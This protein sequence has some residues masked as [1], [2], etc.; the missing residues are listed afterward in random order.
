MKRLVTKVVLIVWL[1]LLRVVPSVAVLDLELTKGVDG[2][3]PIAVVPFDWQSKNAKPPE[4]VSS[5]ISQDLSHSGRFTLLESKL[6]TQQPHTA[7][8]VDLSHWRSKNVENVLVGSI[9]PLSDGKY[10]VVYSLLDLYQDKPEVGHDSVNTEK[11]IISQEL[12]VSAA[13]LRRLAHHISDSIYEALTGEKGIFST[14]IAYVLV[15][16]EPGKTTQYLLEVADMDGHNPRPILRSNEPIMSPSWSP[17][18]KKIAYVSFENK[19]PRVY[20]SDLASGKRKMMTSFPGINGAPAWSPDSKQLALA[21]S[22]GLNPNLYLLEVASGVLTQLTNDSA[23]NTE[24][25]WAPDGHSLLFTS[26]RGGTPQIY[27]LA[28]PSKAISRVT[29]DGRYNTTASFSPDGKNL[30]FLHRTDNGFNIATR[31]VDRDALTV[32]THNGFEESPSFAP[33][34]RMIV[35]ATQYGGRGVLGIVS[36]DGRVRLRLPAQKGNVQEPVWSPFAQ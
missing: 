11:V 17:D 31:N 33:N 15:K 14:R 26:D 32:L 16:P 1:G 29:F 3:I 24:P 35:Y 9:Q 21:L 22:E 4:D 30:V 13:E 2:A 10:R 12:T 19:R 27:R 5:V 8:A 7:E 36:T 28:L 18:G 6:I 25:K 20:V 23:I 34:G